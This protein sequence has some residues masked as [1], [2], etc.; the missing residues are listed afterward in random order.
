MSSTMTPDAMVKLLR[1]I[2]RRP[3]LDAVRLVIVGVMKGCD[4]ETFFLLQG[5]VRK[6]INRYRRVPIKNRDW[7][8]LLM[9]S[10]CRPSS[11]ITR[12]LAGAR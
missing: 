7:C 11:A 10:C 4:V 1:N 2:R 12:A 5:E 3:D 8:P 9:C 6:A